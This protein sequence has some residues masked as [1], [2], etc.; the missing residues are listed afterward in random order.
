MGSFADKAAALGAMFSSALGSV[1]YFLNSFGQDLGSFLRN[2]SLGGDAGKLG[3][4]GPFG[5]GAGLNPFFQLNMRDFS[6]GK[7]VIPNA[8]DF[9]NEIGETLDIA[10]EDLKDIST[11]TLLGLLQQVLPEEFATLM[12]GLTGATEADIQEW[13]D[14]STENLV[15]DMLGLDGVPTYEDPNFIDYLTEYYSFRK[16]HRN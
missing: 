11:E 5:S 15:L 8:E 12:G 7:N 3:G 9:K 16:R 10:P 1:S 2:F 14:K 6:A 13:V 4:S